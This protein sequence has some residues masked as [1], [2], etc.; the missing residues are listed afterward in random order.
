MN[1]RPKGDGSYEYDEK[2]ERWI[3]KI[4]INKRKYYLTSKKKSVLRKKVEEFQKNIDKKI[5][6]KE[7]EK[8]VQE[9]QETV[10]SN[11]TVE[12]WSERWLNAIK[13][14]IKIRT[15][16]YYQRFIRLYIN[17]NLGIKPLG[18]VTT[19]MLQEMLND[20]ATTKGVRGNLLSP[21]TIN[22]IRRTANAMFTYAVNSGLLDTNPVKNT[23]RLREGKSEIMALDISRVRKLIK[24]ASVGDYIY[25]NSNQR[26]EEDMGMEYL[27]RCYYCA[28]VVEVG[29]GLRQGELF[30]L[31][32]DDVD[33]KNN[34][35]TVKRNM[36]YSSE[37]LI[38]DTPKTDKFRVVSLDEK[39]M[40]VIRE[41]HKWQN[42]YK[43]KMVGIYNNDKQLIF[44]N[45]FG[46]PVDVSNYIN[47]HWAK[48]KKAAG[49][50]ENFRWY[51]LRHTHATLLLLSGVPIK[52]VSERLGHATVTQTVNTYYNLIPG[53]QEQAVN[54]L[55]KMNILSDS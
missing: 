23:K 14:T 39:T 53:L 33:L 22:G 29:S 24:I 45:S 9:I 7:Q 20:L 50:P 10:I 3:W 42:S 15:Y 54:A 32:W 41:W 2:Q 44:T 34:K 12:E 1:R 36:Q 21:G 37:G 16:D 40:K 38:F 8:A 28:L 30:A 52:V 49:L 4:Y 31:K 35:L 17:P 5:L 11:P 26:Y 6:E 48:L 47:G 46:K 13:P 51:D 19:I 18:E 27:R 25:Q 55:D 43:V